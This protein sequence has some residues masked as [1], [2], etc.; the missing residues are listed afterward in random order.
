V[1]SGA[2][3][4]Q[5]YLCSRKRK[6]L[7]DEIR[8]ELSGIYPAREAEAIALRLFE[9][10]LQVSRT[11]LY[12]DPEAPVEAPEAV[13]R[14][15]S[16]LKQGRPVQYGLGK[17]EFYGLRLRVDENVL[18][19]RPETEELVRRVLAE[20]VAGGDFRVLDIGTGSGAIAIALARAWP[21]AVV[22]AIDI[23]PGALA[24]ARENARRNEVQV[25]F[26]AC[27]ILQEVPTGRFDVIVSNPPYVRPSER[28]QMHPNVLNHEP[29]LALF[30][31][32]D[33]PLLFYRRIAT[34]ARELLQSGGRL[35][36]EIN[37]AMGTEIAHLLTRL[38]YTCVEI[39]T[40]LSGK[41]RIARGI[42]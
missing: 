16:E 32:E 19:P 2:V 27:D 42:V 6:T 23:S 28:A 18:I 35:Y 33:D 30:V 20:N 17:T 8:R 36:F 37:E 13:E 34:T 21:E 10:L 41:E 11:A 9:E 14:A 4:R 15:L 26:S 24:V 31:P 25:R 12:L 40:D 3:R 5:S 38:G 22:E 29:E 39:H 1:E 7:F